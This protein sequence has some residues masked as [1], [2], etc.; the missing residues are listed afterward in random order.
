MCAGLEKT[1]CRPNCTAIQ[2]RF[3]VVLRSEHFE[4]IRFPF[5]PTKRDS[6]ADREGLLAP[7]W[8]DALTS[9]LLVRSQEADCLEAEGRSPCLLAKFADVKS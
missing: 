3:D 4:I 6:V 5:R 7:F 1:L 8:E 9:D 2:Q